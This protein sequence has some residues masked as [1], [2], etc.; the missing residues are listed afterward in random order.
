[1]T[2]STTDNAPKY[3]AAAFIRRQ[4]AV[5][6]EE[7]AS[8][9]VVRDNA[10]TRA[11]DIGAAGNALRRLQQRLEQVNVVVAVHAL[12]HSAN[13]LKTH[14]GIDGRLRQRR[15]HAIC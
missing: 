3:I 15:E 10:Q 1:M 4:H 14:A 7:A 6:N 2:N 9:D 12:H 13:T 11:G 5:C 8:A